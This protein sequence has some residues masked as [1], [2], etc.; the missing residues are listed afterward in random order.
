MTS[1]SGTL[2]I[3]RVCTAILA[4]F[5]LYEV[6][7]WH[8]VSGDGEHRVLLHREENLSSPQCEKLFSFR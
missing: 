1:S 8:M 3:E 5:Y 2:F 6:C 7:P 4:Y